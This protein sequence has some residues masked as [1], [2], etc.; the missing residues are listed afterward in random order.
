MRPVPR[1][2]IS[3]VRTL[4][5]ARRWPFAPSRLADAAATHEQ[6]VWAPLAVG[7][8]VIV[9]LLLR[10]TAAGRLT[11]HVDEAASV[12]AAHMVAEQGVPILPS[13]TVYLQGATLSYLLAPLVWLG[14]GGLGDLTW[15]RL[16]SVLAGTI[17]VYLGYRVALTATRDARAGLVT[18]VLIALDPLRVCSGAATSACTAS[19]RQSPS[20]SSGSS[21]AC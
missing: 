19:C 11:S 1:S 13:G 12:L 17:A 8:T 20:P 9:G 6:L 21:S 16:V 5:D 7:I 3:T 2:G 14:K 18:A 10:L 4:P 15:M